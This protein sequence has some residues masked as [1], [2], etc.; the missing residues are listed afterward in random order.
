M[1]KPFGINGIST[2]GDELN[3]EEKI[4]PPLVRN[5]T[6]IEEEKGDT[7]VTQGD[8]QGDNIDLQNLQNIIN[9][10]VKEG[11][12]QVISMLNKGIEK[13]LL[14]ES[15]DKLDEIIKETKK[16]TSKPMPV[17]KLPHQSV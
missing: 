3:M 4:L 7:V 8:T 2:F 11:T 15:N 9:K 13:E 5:T 1:R 10:G 14:S 6:V 12:E 16:K 17:N